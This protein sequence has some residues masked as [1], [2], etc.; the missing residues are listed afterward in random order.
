M[1]ATYALAIETFP[2]VNP[3]IARARRR[4]TNG[5]VT[6]NA[7]LTDESKRKSSVRGSPNAARNTSQ[8]TSVPAWLSNRILRR[9]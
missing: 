5:S 8:E 6:T 3:S 7:P 2:P 4:T 9:P 1:S